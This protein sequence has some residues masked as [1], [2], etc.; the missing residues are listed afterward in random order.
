MPGVESKPLQA[1]G[2]GPQWAR[3]LTRDDHA[4]VSALFLRLFALIHFA[5]FASFGVQA[6]GLIG[7]GGIL[8]LADYVDAARHYF[9][10]S[11]YWEIPFVFWW[12]ASDRSIEIVVVLGL[13][14][15][16]VLLAGR[17]PRLALATLY[18]LYLSLLYAG[19]RFMTYQWDILLVETTALAF[20]LPGNAT[21]GTWLL[22]WLLFRFMFLSGAVKLL[23]GDPSW[24]SLT[25]LDYHYETQPLPTLLAWYAHQLPETFNRGCVAMIFVV[26]L[27]VPFLIF[28]PRIAR[29]V[30]AA[31]FAFLE[32]LIILTGNYNF[33]NLLT[34]LLCLSLLDDRAL[35]RCVPRALYEWLAPRAVRFPGIKPVTTAAA[36]LA[37][38]VL[39]SI[40]MVQLVGMFRGE[41]S[42]PVA[43]VLQA[44]EP[45][46]LVNTYGLFAVMTTE[47]IEI[48][49]EGSNDGRTWKPYEFKYKPGD[50]KRAPGWLIPHQPR[51]DWQMW[52]AAL[53]S[54]EENPWFGRFL[55]CLLQGAPAV[56]A[57]LASNPFPD[58]PP[59]YVRA[60][61]YRY[62]F[63]D[64][65]TRAATG[66]WWTRERT[67]MYTAPVQLGTELDDGR[68]P[69]PH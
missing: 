42:G 15:S 52:F 1:I 46:R 55:T 9:G 67:G 20:F 32:F 69:S 65:S 6:L 10:A 60:L 40:G 38:A 39:I 4:R 31:A 18:V 49:V 66:Q 28:G 21:I 12:S 11:G 41:I 48:V 3:T 24:A 5:A 58:H 35:V 53:G 13:V 29:F 25:A 37:G 17:L 44:V 33:F 36:A 63:S 64:R 56:T 19:Q 23:S 47:R 30:A 51:L 68:K 57:L 16:L 22:R 54:F 14:A 43:D 50:L 45:F 27:L 34:M 26:E 62:H 61:T 59:R 2:A 7:S 8:P